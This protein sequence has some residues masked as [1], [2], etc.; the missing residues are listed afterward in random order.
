MSSRVSRVLSWT[1]NFTVLIDHQSFS[2]HK[3]N[4]IDSQNLSRNYLKAAIRVSWICNKTVISP[5]SEAALEGQIQSPWGQLTQGPPVAGRRCSCLQQTVA[6]PSLEKLQTAHLCT[7]PKPAQELGPYTS[8]D[9]KDG[10]KKSEERKKKASVYYV[11][12]KKALVFVHYM[13]HLCI[14]IQ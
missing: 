11:H 4:K 5:F 14:C 6:V 13:F 10:S 2:C 3:K 9:I 1:H 7:P 12:L 8:H